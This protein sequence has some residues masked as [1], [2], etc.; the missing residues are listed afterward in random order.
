MDNTQKPT[1]C[2]ACRQEIRFITM[3]K[4][5]KYMPVDAAL[6]VSQ[7]DDPSAILITT[8]GILQRGV[9]RG[10]TGYVPHWSTCHSAGSFRK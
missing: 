4:T 9:K 7:E 1:I 5:S 6:H 8:D 2:K 10:D 3:Q